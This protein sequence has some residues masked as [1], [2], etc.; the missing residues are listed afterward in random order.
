MI[1]R[2]VTETER[3]MRDEEDAAERVEWIYR[4]RTLGA[5]LKQSGQYVPAWYRNKKTGK[6]SLRI[7]LYK[8]GKWHSCV[9]KP[10]DL[11]AAQARVKLL[12][13]VEL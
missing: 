4:L 8:N 7:D 10:T 3:H 1:D 12:N 6:L 13:E 9:E 11:A 5:G 2:S